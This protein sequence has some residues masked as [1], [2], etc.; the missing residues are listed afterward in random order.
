MFN[1]LRNIYNKFLCII[2][3]INLKI[4]F[5][6]DDIYK[7]HVKT[8]FH[9]REYK[10]KAVAISNSI[11]PGIV[12][13]IGCGLGDVISRINIDS[14]YKFGFDS[15]K[16]LK[17]SIDKLYPSKFNFFSDEESL[18]YHIKN[19]L[20]LVKG[21]LIIILLNFLHF[22]AEDKL[23]DRINSYYECFGPFILIIDGIENASIEFPY[24]HSRFLDSQP[25][26]MYSFKNIDQVR[27]L[28]CIDL[29]YNNLTRQNHAR[30]I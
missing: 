1:Y 13:D 19:R 9:C 14:K 15:D 23:C 21:P 12:I 5:R 20:S 25:G 10:V 7:W 24:A 26:L 6:G 16:R 2:E 3:R 22:T 27:S 28:Y 18:K 17:S 4:I 8:P 11:K 30:S 29:R